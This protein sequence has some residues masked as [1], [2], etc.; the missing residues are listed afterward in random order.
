MSVFSERL[1]EL[2]IIKGLTQK[3]LA[4][5]IHATER[6]VQRYESDERKPTFDAIIAL[7]NGLDVSTDY[8]FG[9]TNNPNSHKIK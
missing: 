2:R 4:I 6:G 5:I 9:R 8:L 3:Q 7:A 1:K